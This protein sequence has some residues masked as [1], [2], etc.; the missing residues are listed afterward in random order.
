MPFSSAIASFAVVAG[1]LTIMPGLDTALGLRSAITLGKRRAFATALGI[2]CGG[3]GLAAP[4][5][6]RPG[7]GRR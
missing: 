1:M 3:R 6:Y 7:C 4:R 2:L 5:R